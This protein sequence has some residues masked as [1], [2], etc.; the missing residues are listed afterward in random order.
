MVVKSKLHILACDQPWGYGAIA[1]SN[2]G[3]TDQAS[4]TIPQTLDANVAAAWAESFR[5]VFA[6]AGTPVGAIVHDDHFAA[7]TLPAFTGPDVH[8][9]SV[10]GVNVDTNAETGTAVGVDGVTMDVVQAE[11]NDATPINLHRVIEA[12]SHRPAIVRWSRSQPPGAMTWLPEGA[13]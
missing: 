13:T 12:G 5:T 6:S 8:V 3:D 7:T 2:A 9:Y 11:A 4:Y 10:G 1:S